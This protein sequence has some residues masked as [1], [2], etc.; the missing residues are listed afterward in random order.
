MATVTF[1][2]RGDQVGRYGTVSGSG[3]NQ[4]RIVTVSDVEALGT[5]SD[6]FT[7]TVE[8]V[9]SGVTQFQNGQFITIRDADGNIVVPRTVVQPDIEQGF[10]AGDEHLILQQSNFLIDLAGLPVGPETVTYG[11]DDEIADPDKGDND[12][13]LDFADFVCFATGTQITTPNGL[14]DVADLC[15]GDLVTTLDHGVVP[16]KWIGRRELDLTQP[17]TP[18]P[19]LVKAGTFGLDMPHQDTILSPDHRIYLRDLECEILFGETEVLA[20]AKGLVGLQRIREMKGKKSVEYV[21]LL[22]EHHQVILANGMPSETLYP[23][24]EALARIGFFGRMQIMRAVPRLSAGDLHVCY[25]PARLLLT[26]KET[27]AM[28]TVLKLREQ[29]TRQRLSATPA[30]QQRAAQ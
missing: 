21:T 5:A 19:V 22:T 17:D 18:K 12:G 24:P 15:V 11:F 20:P 16:I 2:V 9:N 13:E 26:V 3:N 4:D 28:A 30:V 8:Q 10:G 25:P 14:R 23:G 27:E 6:V 29:F 7:V 1:E